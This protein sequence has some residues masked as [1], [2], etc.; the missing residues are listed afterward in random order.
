MKSIINGIRKLA[1]G[2]SLKV[3]AAELG[4][5]QSAISHSIRNLETDLGVQLFLRTGKGLVLT[6]A[7]QILLKE[8]VDILRQMRNIRGRLGDRPGAE[9]SHLRIVAGSSFIKTL[10]P[11]VYLEYLECFPGS[12]LSVVAAD[13]ESALTALARNEADAALLVNV[14]DE[15]PDLES[16]PLFSDSLK[17]LLSAE[18]PLATYESIPIHAIARETLLVRKVDNYTTHMIRSEMGRRSFQIKNWVEVSSEAAMREMLR[19]GLGISIEA[20]WAFPCGSE[21]YLLEWKE[22]R[23]VNLRRDWSFAWSSRHVLDR[24]LKSLLRICRSASARMAEQNQPGVESRLHLLPKRL[25][26]SGFRRCLL[27]T[28]KNV[29]DPTLLDLSAKPSGQESPS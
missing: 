6:P 1:H 8:C 4:V 9:S 25:S 3:A 2:G 21:D 11:D 14:D 16:C 20:P 7:G 17:V 24:P 5:T 10:L 29:Q 23:G 22:L 15:D 26:G 28:S 27:P 19:L 12:P 13:R 18:H